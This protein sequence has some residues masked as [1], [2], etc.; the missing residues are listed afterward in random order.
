EIYQRLSFQ[1]MRYACSPFSKSDGAVGLRERFARLVGFQV[2][3]G[4]SPVRSPRALLKGDGFFQQRDC[5]LASILLVV[6]FAEQLKGTG[7]I[8][9]DLN[10]FLKML[11]SRGE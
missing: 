2:G 9:I 4:E 7:V 1:Q 10:R 3:G 5:V 11:V 6:E 8:G